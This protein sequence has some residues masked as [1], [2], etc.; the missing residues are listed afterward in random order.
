MS[1]SSSMMILICTDSFFGDSYVYIIFNDD[2][3][4]YWARS[5][6]LEYLSQVAPNLPSSAKPTLGPDAT[7]VGWVYSYVLQDKTGRVLKPS[8]T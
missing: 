2:T 1:I 8:C 7:G 6:V 4:M 3:D 5:R